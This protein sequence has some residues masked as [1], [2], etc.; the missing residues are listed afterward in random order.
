MNYDF[1]ASSPNFFLL[2]LIGSIIAWGVIPEYAG[3]LVI[4]AWL[5]L[6]GMH[7]VLG[8]VIGAAYMLRWLIADFFLALIGGFGL[9]LGLRG[10]GIGSRYRLPARRIWRGR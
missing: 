4:L 9:G 8:L 5:W 2:L 3:A 10:S 7:P 1:D 6:L